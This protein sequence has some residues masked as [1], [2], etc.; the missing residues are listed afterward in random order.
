[1]AV[2]ANECQIA[3]QALEWLDKM[4]LWM[5]LLLEDD[6]A[7]QIINGSYV[8]RHNAGTLISKV[9]NI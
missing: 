9:Y 8:N 5:H 6:K 7:F 1:M 4:W 3:V 2:S